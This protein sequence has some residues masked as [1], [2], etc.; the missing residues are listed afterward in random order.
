MRI[1]FVCTNYNNAAYTCTAIA[2]LRAGSGST[3]RQVGHSAISLYI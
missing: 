1:G 3:P 2:S